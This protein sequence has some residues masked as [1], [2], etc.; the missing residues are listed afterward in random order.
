MQK[1]TGQDTKQIKL[2]PKQQRVYDFICQYHAER[3]RVPK[4]PEISEFMEFPYAASV[5]VI[6]T[7]LVKKGLICR[8]EGRRGYW[9]PGD[10][11]LNEIADKPRTQT[12]GP[13]V[14]T[15]PEPEPAGSQAG[16]LGQGSTGD[17]FQY[18][19]LG[20]GEAAT[21]GDV[22]IGLVHVETDKEVAALEVIAPASMGVLRR[23]V[24]SDLD[25]PQQPGQNEILL[26]CMEKTIELMAT[27]IYR[28]KEAGIQSAGKGQL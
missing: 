14:T 10:P 9:M 27:E 17:E 4:Q 23:D 18:I 20:I 16:R 19:R 6:L 15:Q 22:Y 2:A 7:A 21:I 3:G 26:R 1:S 25:Q 24:S 11:A 8:R 12:G 28:L 5:W 13:A